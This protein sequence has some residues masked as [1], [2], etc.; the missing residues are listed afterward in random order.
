MKFDTLKYLDNKGIQYKTSGKNIGK[1]IGI[2]HCPFCFDASYHLGVSRDGK[3]V[4]CWKCGKHT[5]AEFIKKIEKFSW[6][7]VKEKI[8]EFKSY[9]IDD[10]FQ[11]E[12]IQPSS[13]KLP[14]QFVP[15]FPKIAIEYIESRGYDFFQLRKKYGILWGGETG[16]AKYRII[17]PI[18]ENGVVVS[19]VGRY[20]FDNTSE[21]P[22]MFE[23]DSVALVPRRELLF[24]PDDVQGDT[25]I[26]CE[27]IFDKL[28]IGDGAIAMLSTNFSRMQVLKLKKKGLKKFYLMFDKETQAQ[29]KAKKLEGFLSWGDVNYID[30]PEYANDPDDLKEGDVKYIRRMV[31]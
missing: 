3:V 5:L 11:E 4:N 27:G 1:L 29:E 6:G 7:E 15:V 16:R 19:W 30:L 9:D 12:R 21:M 31:F 28:R 17:F 26:L 18:K 23:R 10:E 20:I 25:A 2:K 14:K 22:Y 24:G 8:K 13:Y